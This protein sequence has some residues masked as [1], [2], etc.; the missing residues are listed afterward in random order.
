MTA[1][2]YLPGQMHDEAAIVLMAYIATFNLNQA[3][4]YEP[5]APLTQSVTLDDVV[6]TAFLTDLDMIGTETNT[7]YAMIAQGDSVGKAAIVVILEIIIC[8]SS[9]FR[10]LI[11]LYITGASFCHSNA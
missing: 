9:I 8:L 2:N 1:L 5:Q 3:M 10:V 11:I 4:G 6:S 7:L